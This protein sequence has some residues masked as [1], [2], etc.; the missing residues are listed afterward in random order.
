M[1][2][3]KIIKI[4]PMKIHFNFDIDNDRV[5]DNKDCKPF[6]KHRQDWDI[7]TPKKKGAKIEYMTPDVYIRKTGLIP[8]KSP[9]YYYKYLEKYYDTEK[10]EERPI[11][12]L[13]EI[14]K[15]PHKKVDIPWVGETPYDHEGRHRAYAAQLAGQKRIPVSVSSLGEYSIEWREKLGREFVERMGLRDPAY[16]EEWMNRFRSGHPEDWMDSRSRKV[17]VDMMK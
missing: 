15:S 3:T 8:E 9:T 16:A 2:R 17:Y 4:K 11:S 1:K 14:I 5:I 12:E 10:D 7:E 6:D 13:T